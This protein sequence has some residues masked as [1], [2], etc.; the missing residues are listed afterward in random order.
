ML[1][2]T[3]KQCKR[4]MD[5]ALSKV[6]A[7]SSEIEQIKQQNKDIDEKKCANLLTLESLRNQLSTAIQAQTMSKHEEELRLSLK[8]S[9]DAFPQD[10]QGLLK[11]MVTPIKRS[12]GSYSKMRW[13]LSERSCLFLITSRTEV[14]H[15][16]KAQ[17]ETPSDVPSCGLS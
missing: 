17:N 4:S 9:Q 16:A 12:T 5:D 15:Y 14:H 2:R 1:E 8:E 7:C 11:T 10:V 3:Q 6:N 13:G